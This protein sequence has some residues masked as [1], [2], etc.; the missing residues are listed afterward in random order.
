MVFCGLFGAMGTKRGPNLAIKI[1]KLGTLALKM[2]NAGKILLMKRK[3]YARIGQPKQEIFLIYKNIPD[4]NVIMLS[5]FLCLWSLDCTALSPT[6]S[7]AN[8]DL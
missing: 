4:N 5:T 2:Q 7:H 8:G 1:E 6:S 3:N